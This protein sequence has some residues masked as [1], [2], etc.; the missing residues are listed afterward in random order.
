MKK[1]T[2]NKLI[3]RAEQAKAPDVEVADDVLAILA[4]QSQ[5]QELISYRP[6]FWIAS[7]SSAAAAC[8]AI[9]AAVMMKTATTGGLME[10]YHTISWAAQ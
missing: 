6:L 5:Q 7:V 1:Q 3:R 8:I 9:V 10:L 2:F 4:S